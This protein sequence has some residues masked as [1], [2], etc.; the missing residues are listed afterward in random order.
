VNVIQNIDI[1]RNKKF[2]QSFIGRINFLRIFIPNFVEIIK[3]ITNM[4]KKDAEIKWTWE[5]KSSFEKIKQ[6]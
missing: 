3:L 5:A 6:A 4:I 2:I 1:P